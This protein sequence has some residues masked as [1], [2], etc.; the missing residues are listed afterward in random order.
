MLRRE[1]KVL[2]TPS[3]ARRAI[4]PMKSLTNI[5]VAS[6][7]L[8]IQMPVIVVGRHDYD[9]YRD[10]FER[11]KDTGLCII[12]LVVVVVVVDSWMLLNLAKEGFVYVSML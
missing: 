2:N 1:K 9:T 10:A 3:A 4:K 7:S 11:L 12:S 6:T 5:Q 8:I